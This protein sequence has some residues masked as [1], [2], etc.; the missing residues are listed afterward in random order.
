MIHFTVELI[1]L[2]I[3]NEVDEY[4]VFLPIR[5]IYT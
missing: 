1:R 3:A 5:Y 2:Q 4:G